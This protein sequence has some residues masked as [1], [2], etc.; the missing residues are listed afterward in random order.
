VFVQRMVFPRLALL[1][2]NHKTLVDCQRKDKLWRKQCLDLSGLPL[3]NLNVSLDLAG[4]IRSKLPYRRVS[5]GRK[6]F[7]IR[8]IDAFNGMT[9]IVPC[10]LL[11]EL[12][13]GV[14]VLHHEAALVLGTTQFSV[15]TFFPLLTYVLLH[16]QLPTIHAQLHLLE[17]Y[18]VTHANANGEEAYYVY[19]VH[20]AVEY[21]CNTSALST[22]PAPP[23][24]ATTKASDEPPTEVPG[25]DGL[26]ASAPVVPAV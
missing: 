14:V 13:Y 26:L 8:A 22:V 9:S 4:K 10:D 25:P 12:M 11:E 5:G 20:A 23:A 15:E 2:F 18:A 1:C 3:E 24:A 6:A 17:N 21:V 19:C 16:C 7:L